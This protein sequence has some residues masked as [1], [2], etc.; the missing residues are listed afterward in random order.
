M[1]GYTPELIIQDETKLLSII[2]N[3]SWMIL[4]YAQD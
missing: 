4:M 3:V 2:F 1:V